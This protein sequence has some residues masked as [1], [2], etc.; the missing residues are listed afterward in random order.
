MNYCTITPDR[1][2]R[3]V[4]L[5]FCENR[6]EKIVGSN[7]LTISYEPLSKNCDIIPR[8]RH[9]ITVCKLR[10]YQWAFIIENDDYYPIDYIKNLLPH[11]E[12]IDFIG[13]QNTFYYNIKTRRYQRMEHETHSSLF[14]TGFRISALDD[15]QW[16]PDDNPFLDIALW[17]HAK[18]KHRWKLLRND[19]PCIGIKGH[20]MGKM[21]GKGHRLELNQADPDMKWF[22]AKLNDEKAFE[23][24]KSI[25]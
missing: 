3:P 2:D 1:G 4:L 14:C 10:S 16:P 12:N 13:Y 24:Y 9:G 23:F 17:K 20:G 6:F 8:I 22:R 7:R 11:L 18:Q 19:N 15:F 25:I 5:E 21:G